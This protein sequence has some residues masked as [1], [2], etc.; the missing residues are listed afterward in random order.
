MEQAA[1]LIVDDDAMSR[2][3][4]ARRLSPLGFDTTGAAGGEDA[5][6]LVGRR[7]FDLVLLDITMPGMSGM[8]TLSALRRQYSMTDLPII[9]V[10]AQQESEAIVEALAHSANDYVTKPIDFPVALARI[11]TQL[12]LRETLLAL[13]EANQ[14]LERLSFQDGLTGVANRRCFDEY[15]E[16]EW[17]RAKRDQIPVSLIFIDIDLFKAF[18]DTYGHEAGDNTLKA[19]ARA[20]SAEAKRSTDLVARYGGE[21]FVA[22][23]PDTDEESAARV[24]EAMRAGIARLAIP[25]A[26]SSVAGSVT[27]SVGVATRY[28]ARE[29]LVTTLISAA[30]GALYRAKDDGRNCVRI[31]DALEVIAE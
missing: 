4:L 16:R 31:A 17:K 18:N 11:R 30:D 8:D 13:A 14:K 21:E 23:L 12:L 22:V 27:I 15:L 28:P 10:T 24:G 20:M 6:V 29:P 5:L 2:E 25:H 7:R 26:K 3:I 9:M 1:I 19:V